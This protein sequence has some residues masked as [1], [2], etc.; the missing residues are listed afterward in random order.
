MTVIKVSVRLTLEVDMDVWALEYGTDGQAAVRADVKS[1]ALEQIAGCTAAESGAF[2]KV[3][4]V[5]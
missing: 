3:D 4:L 2:T 5:P 1:Y